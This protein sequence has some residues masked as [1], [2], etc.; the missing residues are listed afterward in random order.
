V[1]HGLEVCFLAMVPREQKL[2]VAEAAQDLG[3]TTQA[4]YRRISNGTLES[5]RIRGRVHVTRAAVAAASRDRRPTTK[6]RRTRT[7]HPGTSTAPTLEEVCRRWLATQH[8]DVDNKQ[9]HL[10]WL[11]RVWGETTHIDAIDA[12]QRMG[13]AARLAQPFGEKATATSRARRKDGNGRRRR[14][15][16]GLGAGTINAICA[17]AT[18]IFAFAAEMEWCAAAKIPRPRVPIPD[19]EWFTVEELGRLLDVA[20]AYRIAYLLGARAGLRRGEIVELRWGDIDD[21]A[22]RVARAY[23]RKGHEWI[24]STTKSRQSRSIQMPPDLCDALRDGRGAADALVVRGDDGGRLAPWQLSCAVQ[25]HAKQIGI[26]RPGLGAHSLRHSFCSHLAQQG[27]PP[28]MIQH[29]AGHAHLATTQRYLHLAPSHLEQGMRYLPPL[30]T[31]GAREDHDLR[32][33]ETLLEVNR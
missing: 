15:G 22:I 4:V 28:L 20:G 29:L 10:H 1:V 25:E 13:L 33:V 2:T 11:M 16:D 9:R 19:A 31:D 3:M 21:K 17:T 24:I 27:C 26:V 12:E 18:R 30:P 8:A 6:S 32:E 14:K 5:V 23:K 7:S